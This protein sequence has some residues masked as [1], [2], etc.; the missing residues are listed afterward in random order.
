[1]WE[2]T[3]SFRFEAAH[4]LSG[5]SLGAAGAG[6]HGHSFRA[7]IVIRGTP[8]PV[9]G[10]VMDLGILE[11]QIEGVRRTLD[12]KMLND[13]A[14]LERPTLEYIARFIWSR[15]EASAPLV[16]VAVHRDSCGESCAYFGQK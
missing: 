12:H 11:Q 7:E 15:V 16:K 14:G 13:I 1:M 3:K 9:T 2:L 4:Q 6:I 10:M 8:D 5:T